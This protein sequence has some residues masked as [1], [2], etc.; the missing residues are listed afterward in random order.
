M[1]HASFI[2]FVLAELSEN[3]DCLQPMG[4]IKRYP[5]S[6]HSVYRQSEVSKY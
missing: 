6:H 1:R 5:L 3:M 2:E 4:A